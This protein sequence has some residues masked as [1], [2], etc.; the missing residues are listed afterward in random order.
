MLGENT[1]MLFEK[2]IQVVFL[3]ENNNPEKLK[4]WN[5]FFDFSSPIFAFE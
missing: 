5:L 2:R 1:Q 3:P 4:F